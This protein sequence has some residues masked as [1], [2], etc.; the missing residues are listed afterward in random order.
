MAVMPDLDSARLLMEKLEQRGIPPGS[1]GLQGTVPPEEDGARHEMPEADA[2]SD[3]GRSTGSGAMIGVVVG[4]LLGA[5]LT[6]PFTGLPMVWA[7][8]FGAVFGGGIGLAAGGMAV[9]KF[10]SPAWRESYETARQGERIT[11]G[12][13][14]E[15]PEVLDMAEDVMRQ[16]VAVE[17]KRLDGRE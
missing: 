5:L 7:V 15:D 3:V 12:V 8:L 17:V 2:I 4:G 10:N 11:V 16:D 9:A 14:D 6:I 13:R 1:I